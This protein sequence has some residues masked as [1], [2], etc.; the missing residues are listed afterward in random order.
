M[1]RRTRRGRIARDAGGPGHAAAIGGA[2]Q[3][4]FQPCEFFRGFRSGRGRLAVRL[5]WLNLRGQFALILLADETVQA[6]TVRSGAGGRGEEMV[7]RRV[8][9][10]TPAIAAGP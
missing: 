1:M 2:D 9:A 10:A 3:P 6:L 8:S 7:G 4:V 5:L